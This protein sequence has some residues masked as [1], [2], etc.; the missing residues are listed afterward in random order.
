MESNINFG[1]NNISDEYLTINIEKILQL[2][3]SKNVKENDLIACKSDTH[4]E[5]LIQWLACNKMGVIPILIAKEYSIEKIF[6]ICKKI[7]IK[8]I[9]ISSN[10][11]HCIIDSYNNEYSYKLNGI[12]P[13][14]VIHLTSA[15]T[16]NPKLVLR[17][18]EQLDFEVLRYCKYLKLSSS[19][20]FLPI[21]PFYH[22]F[23]FISIMLVL[24]KLKARLIVPDIIL[25]RN[26]IDLINKYKVTLIFGVPYFFNKMIKVSDKYAFSDSVRYIISSGS[27]MERNLQINFYNKFKKNLLQQYGSTET[28]ALSISSSGDNFNNVGLPLKGVKFNIVKDKNDKEWIY[29]LA[30]RTIG[31]YVDENGVLNLKDKLYKM[32]DLGHIDSAGKLIIEGRGDDILI[33]AGKKINKKNVANVIKKI[34]DIKD[35]EI[36]IDKNLLT[37]ELCCRYCSNMEIKT[38]FFI[39]YCKQFLTKYEIPKNYFRVFNMKSNVSWKNIL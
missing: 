26:I 38:E 37:E 6:N 35:A 28:G 12:S 20:I 3:I 10:M 21:V 29:V 39:K 33:L 19:D 7:Y 17:K 22:S 11:E 5:T 9:L 2:F 1:E 30:N 4:I 31:S 16:G 18:K 8:G 25:P 34:P 36:Y 23:G 15:T 13:G 24:L 32:G 27:A 14:A